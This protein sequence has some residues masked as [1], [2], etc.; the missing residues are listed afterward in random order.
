VAAGDQAI[1]VHNL[2]PNPSGR[3]PNGEPIY[4]IPCG[5][6][7]GPGAG[8]RIPPELLSDYDV[9][10]GAS[11]GSKTPLCSYC[12]TNTANAIDHVSPRS[13][14]GDLT[15]NNT[16]PICTHCNSSKRDRVA[17]KTPPSGYS[18]PW[19]PAHWPPWMRQG[20]RNTYR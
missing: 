2:K 11:P 13:R 15:D 8:E 5:S 4:D 7:G 9:G 14:G 16:T 12:R 20:W 3:G 18:G 10:V 19:P 6:I 1:L 17:P